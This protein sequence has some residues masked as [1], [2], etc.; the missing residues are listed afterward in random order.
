MKYNEGDYYK[1]HD[2]LEAIWLSDKK[3]LFIKGLLQW[4]VGL[5]HYSYGNVKGT[6]LMMQSALHYLDPYRPFY[7]SL[8]IE[9]IINFIEICLIIIPKNLDRVPYGQIDQLPHLPTLYLYMEQ[10]S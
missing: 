1:C 2:L 10:D 7:W 3:N 8:N 9:K 6:R 4:C 5:Y